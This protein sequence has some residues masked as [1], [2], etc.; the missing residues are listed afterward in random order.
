MPERTD[1]N[2]F[3]ASSGELEHERIKLMD[4]IAR[5]NK[6]FDNLHL[7]A[8]KWEHELTA[9]TVNE[10]EGS[11]QGAI[12]RWLNKCDITLVLIHTKLG[13]FTKEEYELSR[14]HKKKVFVF[15]KTGFQPRSVKEI[16]Q[17]REVLALK[18]LL[19][20]EGK[21]Q[22]IEYQTQAELE[23]HLKNNLTQYLK[24]RYGISNPSKVDTEF[25]GTV[26]LNNVPRYDIDDFVG[27]DGMLQKVHETLT[28]NRST[29]L[30]NGMGGVGKTTLAK[31]YVAKYGN[32]YNNIIWTPAQEG[33]EAGIQ[34]DVLL[35][36]ELKLTEAKDNILTRCVNKL[37]T[38]KGPNL[39]VI[40]NAVDDLNQALLAK[41]PNQNWKVLLTSRNKI[42][43]P[44]QV[45]V[46]LM[47]K[48]DALALFKKHYKEP[49]DNEDLVNEINAVVGY[50][51]LTVEL[52]GKL[53]N[54]LPYKGSL[55]NL[56]ED[57]SSK[58]LDIANKVTLDATATSTET[59]DTLV[60]IVQ[61]LFDL[62][63]VEAD[64]VGLLKYWSLLPN[65]DLTL[66]DIEEI[67][68]IEQDDLHA[69]I[70]S[71]NTKG[72]LTTGN[73]T[74]RCHQII[75]EAV[76]KQ[77][78]IDSWKEELEG[79]LNDIEKVIA[80]D[81]YKDNPVDKFKW[82][83]YGQSVID[84][85]KYYE[86]KGL[87]EVL[88]SLGYI[89]FHMGRY[90]E[91]KGLRSLALSQ[92]TNLYK[93]DDPV[94]AT[95]QNNLG[96]LLIELGEYKAAKGLLE[97]ALDIDIKH[98]G[99]EHPEVTIKQNNLALVFKD[100]GEY[101]EAKDLLEKA[102]ASSI[103]HYGE[104]HPVVTIRQNNLA[105]VLQELDEYKAAKKLFQKA[106]ASDIKHFGE[107]HPV[108]TVRQNNLALVLQDL[109]EYKEAKDLY[110]KA[111]ASSIKYYGEEHPS[112]AKRYNNFAHL[113]DREGEKEKALTY[114]EKAYALRLKLLGKEHPYTKKVLRSLER[115]K[116][117][118][119]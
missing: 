9:G 111:L 83:I 44:E 52:L 37:Q 95:L 16:D 87:V 53:A 76:L 12:N 21:L 107:E 49:I 20:D 29:L 24:E 65:T 115:V 73:S 89:Y 56:K 108:V 27:R 5:I 13:E 114:F 116:R 96:L 71:L 75:Q 70:D 104:E 46:D 103:K 15:F 74:C 60:N 41:L 85:L 42:D 34:S 88:D 58:G 35:L 54:K 8:R 45:D 51:T 79:Y 10:E 18:E 31:A 33:F 40:D 91:S 14:Q 82:A 106:L 105:T 90:N 19:T 101:K 47:G 36:E 11:I 100:L 62:Q 30:L 72:W 99:E 38:Y 84:N 78:P 113:Y 86:S 66:N 110:K 98:Y 61:K 117:E 23:N 102:L 119:G 68:P 1:V 48:R 7:I 17:Y 22:Y 64:E 94:I 39:W 63:G 81:K 118:L 80:I 67:I 55:E 25:K 69:L 92:A 57:L 77:Y 32:H 6:D 43:G 97:K 59:N 3:I 2:I 109:G 112:V 4:D 50:H 26:Y 28:Q 93:E